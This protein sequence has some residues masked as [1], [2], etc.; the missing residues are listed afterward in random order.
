MAS[1][2]KKTVIKIPKK[3]Q[4][5]WD[6]FDR[7]SKQNGNYASWKPSYFCCGLYE[8][9]IRN[10]SYGAPEYFDR[11]LGVL[12]YKFPASSLIMT[13]TRVGRTRDFIEWV[14]KQL[15]KAVKKVH[16]FTNSKTG[17]VVTAWIL[18]M[19]QIM[20]QFSVKFV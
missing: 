8:A 12:L 9:S 16:T 5:T 18:D 20:E 14:Q 13:D 17:R 2:S 7:Y 6:D 15:P 11:S 1:T 10:T 3:I 19:N 4:G